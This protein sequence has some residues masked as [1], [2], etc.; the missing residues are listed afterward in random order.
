MLGERALS[1]CEATTFEPFCHHRLFSCTFALETW[2][3]GKGWAWDFGDL[4]GHVVVVIIL[5]FQML[6]V[7]STT[8]GSI[9]SESICVRYNVLFLGS[10]LYSVSNADSDAWTVLYLFTATADRQALLLFPMSLAICC[11]SPLFSILF[12]PWIMCEMHPRE[13][14]LARL[15]WA[16]L[17]YYFT[18]LVLVAKDAIFWGAVWWKDGEL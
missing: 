12:L 2:Q 13:Y 3:N 9:A 11:A 14:V 15:L 10:G 16:S 18:S 5:P 6:L 4:F 17:L 7:N 8:E 1:R